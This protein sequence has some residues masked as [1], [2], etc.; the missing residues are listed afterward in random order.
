M[1]LMARSRFLRE[2]DVLASRVIRGRQISP[3]QRAFLTIRLAQCHRQAGPRQL[4][5]KV[6]G[7]RRLVDVELVE[8]VLNVRPAHEALIVENRN[9]FS[10]GKDAE[11]G[12]GDARLQLTQLLFAIL[13]TSPSP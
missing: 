5:A 6:E 9:R 4:F 11:V 1:S 3:R 2:R 7:M 12:I 8:D 10:I 13:Y